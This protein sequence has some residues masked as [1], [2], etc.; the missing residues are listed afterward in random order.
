M[1]QAEA[2]PQTR[3]PRATTWELLARFLRVGSVS[4]GGGQPA[5]P[6]LQR[7]LVE[8]GR[9][10]KHEFADGMAVASAVPGPVLLNMAVFAGLR[11]AGAPG[12]AAALVGAIVPSLLM[13]AGAVTLF[14][15][16][17]ELQPLQRA[18]HGIQP[19][20]LALLLVAGLKLAPAGLGSAPQ[21]LIAAGALAALLAL[22][23]H[24]ALLILLVVTGSLAF[25]GRA[26]LA[27]R[28]RG[29]AWPGDV[30]LTI[31]RLPR[32]ADVDMRC[33][34]FVAID[35]ATC[36]VCLG[37]SRRNTPAAA[38][39]FL[40]RLLAAA[41]FRIRA[42]TTAAAA[43]FTTA[44]RPGDDT[45]GSEFARCCRSLGVTHDVLAPGTA[46]LEDRIEQFGRLL[47][48]VIEQQRLR[49]LHIA[50]RMLQHFAA[51]HNSGQHRA[52][53]SEPAPLQALQQWRTTRPDLFVRGARMAARR[54]PAREAVAA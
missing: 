47:A 8:S 17:R 24:P 2:P 15:Q 9:L 54:T 20:V 3:P 35:R 45:P 46:Q 33:Y 14:L 29:M 51:L 43:V 52:A 25:Q 39:G 50:N 13:M 41:P 34:V 5:I 18:L 37:V 19:A 10:G 23:L 42:V 53:S 30:Y 7:E 1:T 48:R 31:K 40:L 38:A 28:P 22:R 4:F 27:P 11:S 36:W 26:V 44:A 21:A 6:L 49:Q 12:A 32:V 16:F